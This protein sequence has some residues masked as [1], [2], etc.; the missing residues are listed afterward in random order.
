MNDAVCCLRRAD[1]SLFPACASP[2]CAISPRSVTIASSRVHRFC[3]S[4]KPSKA[5]DILIPNTCLKRPFRS[6]PRC[7]ENLG[8]L[9]SGVYS[10]SRSTNSLLHPPSGSKATFSKSGSWF[11]LYWLPAYWIRSLRSFS[12]RFAK[13]KDARPSINSAACWHASSQ[14]T[15][16]LET[17]STSAPFNRLYFVFGPGRL[18]ISSNT[19]AISRTSTR[20]LLLNTL[21]ARLGNT[22]LQ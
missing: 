17:S 10:A 8:V 22:L 7:L 14:Y 2:V 6:L 15:S 11:P 18:L 19:C 13:V 3:S 21:N 5:P 16:Q 20:F 12:S 1:V 4:R 9:K